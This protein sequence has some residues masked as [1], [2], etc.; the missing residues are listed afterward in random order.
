MKVFGNVDKEGAERK[1][2][3]RMISEERR[4]TLLY[5]ERQ[6]AH[7]FQ[8]LQHRAP[9]GAYGKDGKYQSFHEWP[10]ERLHR[11]VDSERCRDKSFLLWPKRG[12]CCILIFRPSG[13]AIFVVFLGFPTQGG[14]FL[15]FPALGWV[16][17][18]CRQILKLDEGADDSVNVLIIRPPRKVLTKLFHD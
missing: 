2:R 8:I 15:P 13:N 9:E 12:D 1:K 16:D 7:P 17:D 4:D 11:F 3:K 14:R 10:Q 5:I 6:R 18:A